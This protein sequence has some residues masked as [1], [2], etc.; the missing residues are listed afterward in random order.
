MAQHCLSME[1]IEDIMLELT[2]QILKIPEDN[3]VVRL[4]YGARSATGSAPMH[5]ISQSV[6]YVAVNPADD[7]YGKQHHI[8]YEKGAEGKLLTEVDE[9]TEE[10]EVIF[11]CYG[12]DAYDKARIIR[13]GL[14]GVKAR[15]ILHKEKIH[16]VVG[17]PRLIQTREIIDT[18]WVRRCDFTA[19]FYVW[20]RIE[21]PDEMNWYE[22]AKITFNPTSKNSYTS[23]PKEEGKE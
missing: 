20:T 22:K 17:M 2:R 12:S 16:F 11:S 4:A 21:R 6:C 1:Q 15:T 10:Y 23:S 13:D 5:N 8:H 3:S 14:Y 18:S 9:Y 19:L 7:G